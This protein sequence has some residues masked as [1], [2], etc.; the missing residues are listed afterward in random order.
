MKTPGKKIQDSP[1]K[2]QRMLQQQECPSSSES[3]TESVKEDPTS[4]TIM[5]TSDSSFSDDGDQLSVEY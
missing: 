5:C 1:V 4:G 2:K 3:D